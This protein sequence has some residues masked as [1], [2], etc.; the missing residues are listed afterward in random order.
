MTKTRSALAAIA[1]T[2]AIMF[3]SA[4]LTDLGVKSEFDVTHEDAFAKEGEDLKAAFT[5]QDGAFVTDLIAVGEGAAYQRVGLRFDAAADVVIEGRVGDDLGSMSPWTPITVTFSEGLAHNGH[6]D[7]AAEHQ[8]AAFAQLRANTVDV[9]SFVALSAIEL[10]EADGEDGL[11]VSGVDDASMQALAAD[12][13]AISRSGWGARNRT[14]SSRHTPQRLTIHHTDTPNNDSLSMAA[15]V[16]QIQAYHVDNRGWCDIGY[17]FLVGQ[18]GRV[19]QGRYEN[20]VGAHAAGANTNN[21]GISFIGTFNSRAP[22]GDMMAAGARIMRALADTYG[23]TLDRT[24]VKGHREVGSSDTDCPGTQ[25]FNN[26]G[27]LISLARQSSSLQPP[28]STPTPPSSGR[29]CSSATLGRSV[30]DGDA[31]QVNYAGCGA[32][33][34]GWYTCSDSAWV[35][36]GGSGQRFAHDA[37]SVPEDTTPERPAPEE[38][39]PEP[40]PTGDEAVIVV[41]SLPFTHSG[42]TRTLRRSNI[43]SYSCEPGTRES[44]AEAVYQVTLS[45]AGT[46]RAA[47]DDVAG[48][49]VD[50]DVH[51]LSRLDASTCIARDNIGVERVLA[52]GTYVVV[53]D[54]WTTSTGQNRAGPYT[55]RLDFTPSS[56]S[57][58]PPPPDSGDACPA[59]VSCLSSENTRVTGNTVAGSRRFDRFSCSGADVSGP[60]RVYRVVVA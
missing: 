12:G 45:E 55:L 20:R 7:V 27:S 51:L 11:D 57:P 36:G 15:R 14:C 6:F 37:C 17:H 56:T 1:T 35:C 40:T 39:T 42:D 49:D 8:G 33:S 53:V 2:T 31:V 18:D 3:S 50:V 19:Y 25:L 22:S 60:E 28:P 52:A 13:I 44:G 46:L 48:D 4:C 43:S 59:G 24:R 32:D 54:T 10:S 23:I 21:V 34:C 26:L 5:A 58:P 38:P 29:A 30:A 41:D 16:R 9:L 47:V